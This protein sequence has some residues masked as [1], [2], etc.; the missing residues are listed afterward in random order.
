MNWFNWGIYLYINGKF[1]LNLILKIG[2]GRS[3]HDVAHFPKFQN[4]IQV[5]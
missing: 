3:V 1:T 2:G 4:D 5:K